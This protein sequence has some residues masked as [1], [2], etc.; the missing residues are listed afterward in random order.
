MAFCQALFLLLKKD[1]QVT[2]PNGSVETAEKF[3]HLTHCDVV[4]KDVL[5]IYTLA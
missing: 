3:L 5:D 1:Y 4:P 2:R